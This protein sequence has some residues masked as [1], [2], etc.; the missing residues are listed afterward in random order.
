[1][2]LWLEF[3]ARNL[4]QYTILSHTHSGIVVMHAN[5]LKVL[6]VVP[7]K[8]PDQLK[9][10]CQ[11]FSIYQRMP[12]SC[13]NAIWHIEKLKIVFRFFNDCHLLAELSEYTY[14]LLSNRQK[15]LS[16]D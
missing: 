5:D 8:I 1:M 6:C 11:T 16:K 12:L 7:M 15:Q 10:Q 14:V 9:E 13:V 4:D 3:L 2:T